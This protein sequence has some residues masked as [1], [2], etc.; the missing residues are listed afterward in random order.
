MEMLVEVNMNANPINVHK[1][2]DDILKDAVPAL[3]VCNN[4]Q[5]R[6]AGDSI[7]NQ[8]N[9]LKKQLLAWGLENKEAVN[10]DEILK[11]KDAAKFYMENY[12]DKKGDNEEKK[13]DNA[14]MRVEFDHQSH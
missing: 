4:K 11:D 8:I 10:F 7:K 6:N 3:E 9:A 14:M 2:I 13:L 12:K 5:I 1:G